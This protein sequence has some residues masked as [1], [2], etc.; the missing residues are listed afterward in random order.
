MVLVARKVSAYIKHALGGE[1]SADV[2]CLDVA[3]QAAVSMESSRKWSYLIRSARGLNFRS[4]VTGTG[5]TY[6]AATKTLTGTELGSYLYVPGD[7][8][9]ITFGG[10]PFGTYDIVGSDAAAGTVTLDAPALTANVIELGFTVNQPRILLPSDFGRLISL[11]GATNGSLRYIYPDS[12]SGLVEEEAY[13]NANTSFTTGYHVEWNS[14]ADKTQPVATLRITPEP[15]AGEFDA[16]SAVYYREWPDL[17]ADDDIV[18]IPSYMEAL[19]IQFCRAFA[20]GYEG[21]GETIAAMQGAVAAVQAGPIY[22][23]AVVRDSAQQLEEGRIRNRGISSA[24][25]GGVSLTDALARTQT[26]DVDFF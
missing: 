2:P 9:S 11:H 25:D 20:I 17:T 6:T 16:L 13:F 18:P 10:A 24:V 8:V 5:A 14:G 19:Y 7:S 21:S 22:R 12:I 3:N 4:P 1:L 26:S 15:T 23:N